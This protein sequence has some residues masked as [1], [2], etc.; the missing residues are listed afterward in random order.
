MVG[1]C[2]SWSL[3]FPGP[4]SRSFASLGG[5]KGLRP[6]GF[7]CCATQGDRPEASCDTEMKRVCR[8]EPCRK[9]PLSYYFILVCNGCKPST[10]KKRAA[11]FL[12]RPEQR[13]QEK[14][15]LQP[16]QQP[17]SPGGHLQGISLPEP[18]SA[19]GCRH[20]PAA[21]CCHN[22]SLESPLALLQMSISRSEKAR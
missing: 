1:S 14:E 10:R 12:R 6:H 15:T 7:S 21:G 5:R 13:K 20:A 2:F 9:M 18:C 8:T 11:F 16:R 4:A 17:A 22:N 3:G 19:A